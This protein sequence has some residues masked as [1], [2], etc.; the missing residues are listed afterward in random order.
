[1]IFDR[2][3]TVSSLLILVYFDRCRTGCRG[4]LAALVSFALK[5]VNFA[6]K[7]INS[8]FTNDENCVLND[9]RFNQT[10]T[11]PVIEAAAAS[12]GAI[13]LQEFCFLY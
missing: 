3:S 7:M 1:M 9:E 2:F 13:S 6:L 11:S 10:G 8:A 12:T 5:M 4:H